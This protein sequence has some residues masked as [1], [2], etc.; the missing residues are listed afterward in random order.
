MPKG[1]YFRRTKFMIQQENNR[2]LEYYKSGLSHRQIIDIIGLSPRQYWKR[3]HKISEEDMEILLM[4]QTKESRAFLHQRMMDKLQ[5][6]ELQASAIAH[7]KTIKTT[8]R[9]AAFHL[10]RQLAADEYSLSTYGP[11]S[12]IIPELNDKLVGGNRSSALILSKAVRDDTQSDSSKD[13]TTD[14]GPV[15]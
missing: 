12:F 3:V 14:P 9:L 13:S 6:Y 10:L 8:D 7:N 1:D 11:S 5:S 15:F 4:D 2:I